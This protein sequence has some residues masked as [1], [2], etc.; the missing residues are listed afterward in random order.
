MNCHHLA[1]ALLACMLLCSCGTAPAKAGAPPPPPVGVASPIAKDHATIR[2]ITGHLEAA[3]TVEL[4]PRVSGTVVAVAVK[5]GAF[6]AAGD[7]ILRIDPAD[8]QAA[9]ARAE[10]D[11][12][13]ATAQL[14]QTEQQFARTSK[15]VDGNLISGQQADDA[16]T[17]VQAATAERAA[18]EAALH[19]A[20]LDLERC[21]VRSP[22]AG[23]IGRI[24]TTVGNVVQGGGP[25]PP[26]LCAVIHRTDVVRAVADLDETAWRTLAPRVAAGETIPVTVGLSGE[27]GLPHS[28]SL[29]FTANQID[30]AT[31]T[32]RLYAELPNPKGLLT[33][34]AFAR[35]GIEISAPRTV[36]LVHER[37]ILAQVATRYVL[38][39]DAQGATAFRPVKLGER[40]G[41]FRVVE[42]GLAAADRIAVNNLAKIFFPGMTVTPVPATMETLENAT[43]PAEAAGK[44][45]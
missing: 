31:G 28:G 11:L 35:I 9:V 8:S 37:A 22:I 3:E 5:D 18:A 41:Q 45:Q 25:V 7:V 34:G 27:D 39:V 44:P 15:L 26:T 10:A 23:T 6:V 20:K 13:Q 30:S 4:K 2:V 12:A 21:A 14:T 32:I 43:P 33:H 29:T 17:A 1:L 36:L 24:L 40:V 38:T 19:T 42:Q 16:A